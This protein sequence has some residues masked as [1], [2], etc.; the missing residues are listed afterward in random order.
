MALKTIP[1]LVLAASAAAFLALAPGLAAASSEA[2]TWLDEYE[3]GQSLAARIPPPRGYERIEVEPGS[4]AAWLRG[5]PLLPSGTPVCYYDGRPKRCRGFHEA[6]MDL[7]VGDRELLP[8]M[9]WFFERGHL[10][11]WP[12][13]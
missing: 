6:V 13:D 2:Y 4:F 5:L 11:R 1:I 9:H 3:P 10:R 7:D 12:P 8:T